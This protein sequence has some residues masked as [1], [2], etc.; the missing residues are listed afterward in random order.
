M[1]KAWSESA[2]FWLTRQR[3]QREKREKV[4]RDA[5]PLLDIDGSDG[6][7]GGD[8]ELQGGNDVDPGWDNPDAGNQ[9]QQSEAQMNLELDQLE[10]ALVLMEM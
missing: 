4:N 9:N 5:F 3:K 2:R 10:E 7:V 8:Q 6:P 1:V